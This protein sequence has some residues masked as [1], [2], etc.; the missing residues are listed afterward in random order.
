[1]RHPNYSQP[2]F[3]KPVQ[4]S[5]PQQLA[6]QQLA[7]RGHAEP[8]LCMSESELISN[9]RRFK[10]AMPRVQAHYAVKANPHPRVLQLLAQEGIGFEIASAHE[11]KLLRDQGIAPSSLYYSNPIKSRDHIRQAAHQGVQWFVV[12]SVAEV[13]KLAEIHP[14]A[15]LYLRIATS[16]AGAVLPLAGKFGCTDGEVDEVMQACK[17]YHMQLAGVSFH[18]GSQCLQAQSWRDAITD[19]LQCFEKM[20]TLGFKPELLNLG[21]GYP[22]PLNDSVPSIESLGAQIESVLAD[23]P[24]H[25]KVIAEPGRNLVASA[26][27]LCTRVVGTAVRQQQPWLYLDTGYYN[28]L[29]ELA[30]HYALP[31]HCANKGNEQMW[32][33]AGP[34]CDSIDTLSRRRAL[35]ANLQADDELFIG[36]TGAYCHACTTQFNGFPEPQIVFV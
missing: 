3:P 24:S 25:I 17:D 27:C 31:I 34:T 8:M 36:H 13:Q 33:I 5:T 2:N 20:R 9:A 32:T 23:V 19:A 16:N 22:T 21:G 26:G 11:L 7:M 1:M 6:Q 29:M 12:D 30:D 15:K 4:T 10:A 35:P 18:V 28:G 14:A